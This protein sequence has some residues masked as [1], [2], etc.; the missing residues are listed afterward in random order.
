[1]TTPVIVALSVAGVL[2]V[3]FGYFFV[4]ILVKFLWGW[5]PTLVSLVGCG[6]ALWNLGLEWVWIAA[7]LLLASILGPWLWQRTT[8]YL[9]VDD[10]LDRFFMLGD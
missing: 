5:W 7:M 1:M 4:G 10:A 6:A 3:V 9:S 8:L 2:I